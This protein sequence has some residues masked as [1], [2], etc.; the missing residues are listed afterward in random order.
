MLCLVYAACTAVVALRLGGALVPV[1]SRWLGKLPLGQCL[2]TIENNHTL[3]YPQQKSKK[4]RS[5]T[6]TKIAP[7][8]E[9]GG[10][11]HLLLYYLGAYT[12]TANETPWMM[13]RFRRQCFPTH[14]NGQIPVSTCRPKSWRMSLF[15]PYGQNWLRLFHAINYLRR[16]QP[17]G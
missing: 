15:A 7:A 4:E 13:T 17:T 11:G 12:R 10:T 16:T 14:S 6:A 9:G 8:G 1:A 5:P 3:W 2:T